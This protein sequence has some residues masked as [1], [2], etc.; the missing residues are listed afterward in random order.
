MNMFGMGE[1]KKSKIPLWEF[2]L[3]IELKDPTKFRK[4]KE[5]IEAQTQKV[6]NM[7]RQGLDTRDYEGCQKLLAA[8]TAAKK[9][10]DRVIRKQGR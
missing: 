6:K 4:N 10:C 3:E 7:M 2:D 9:V 8:F 1:Q 5:G